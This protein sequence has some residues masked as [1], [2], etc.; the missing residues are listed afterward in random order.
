MLDVSVH[1]WMSL[2]VVGCH[3][4]FLDAVAVV[5][6]HWSSLDD[7]VG[8]WTLLDVVR[9]CVCTWLCLLDIVRS[10]WTLSANVGGR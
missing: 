9:L 3:W 4:M 10:C 1:C 2:D 6:Y 8:C 5:G 7:N